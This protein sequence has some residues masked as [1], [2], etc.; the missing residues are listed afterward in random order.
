MNTDTIHI[1]YTSSRKYISFV[2]ISIH[3]ILESNPDTRFHFHVLGEGLTDVEVNNIKAVLPKEEAEL[4]V[5]P[6]TDLRGM[7][8]I[9]VPK[10]FPMIAY[11]RLFLQSVLPESVDRVIYMDGDT[12]VRGDLMPFY[13]SDIGDSLVGG[14]IDPLISTAYKQR[15]GIPADEPYINAGV[16]LIPLA[17]WREEDMQGRFLNILQKNNGTIYMFDQ[18]LVNIGCLGR[19]CLLS[20]KYDMMTNYLTYSYRYLKRYNN[21][22]YDKDIVDDAVQN[23]VL[24]HFTGRLYGR[25]WEEDCIHP[26]KELYLRHKAATA[27]CGNPIQPCSVKGVDKIGVKIYRNMPFL[28]YSIFMRTLFFVTNLKHS[29]IKKDNTQ[30]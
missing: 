25:P 9:D 17:R 10:E 22:F 29:Y 27:Y 15:T 4:S 20:P 24:I 18:G 5:Y 3:S 13:C 2:T 28:F 7:L 16:L 11:A 19:K 14:I 26:Y 8:T 1:A 23:P 30:I 12:V 6:L 21:P